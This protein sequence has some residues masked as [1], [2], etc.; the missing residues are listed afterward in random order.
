MPRAFS[1]GYAGRAQRRD[2]REPCRPR[3]GCELSCHDASE[4][5][6][7][8]GR[9]GDSSV[10]VDR[11]RAPVGARRAVVP[12]GHDR[13]GA[14]AGDSSGAA[15]R[16]C[17]VPH[18]G[19]VPDYCLEATAV[20]AIDDFHKEHGP[21]CVMPGSV[22]KRSQVP[23]GTTQEGTKLLE[24]DEG[25]IAFWHG[26]LWHGSTPRTAPG[27]RTSLH[28]AYCRNFIRPLENYLDIDPRSSRAI[29]LRSR[30]SADWTMRSARAAS[31]GRTSSGSVTRVS[32]GSQA[33]FLPLPKP[34]N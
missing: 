19:T 10:G 34:K 20:W 21:T 9:S 3:S 4:A 12:I 17:R 13:Q 30:L 26:G 16:L 7:D 18:H 27:K 31:K 14:G 15:F 33:T 6:Q 2:A 5:R 22:E 28:N 1:A 29:R 24:M 25:S 23:P 11:R 32:S 8:L